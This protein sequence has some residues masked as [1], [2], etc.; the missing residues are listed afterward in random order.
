MAP[1]TWRLIPRT[2]ILASS[3]KSSRHWSGVAMWA[4][5]HSG[6]SR[7]IDYNIISFRKRPFLQE[8]QEMRRQPAINAAQR[9]PNNIQF[10]G[11]RG[12]FR[13]S[14][15]R[16]FDAAF[17]ARGSCAAPTATRSGE[18]YNQHPYYPRCC[19]AKR[20]CGKYAG[21]DRNYSS[22]ECSAKPLCPLRE[23]VWS[24]RAGALSHQL[25]FLPTVLG[26]NLLAH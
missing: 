23:S 25:F 3:E 21:H 1:T 7:K 17:G 15:N 26:R 24:K 20:R 6:V 8:F 4:L 19:K 11:R 13:D 16:S 22:A 5:S 14:A 18:N 10:K 9:H 12:R 2:G